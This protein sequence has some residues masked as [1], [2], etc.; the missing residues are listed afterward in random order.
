MSNPVEPETFNK[1]RRSVDAAFAMVAGIQL[2]V[3]TGVEEW[4]D[5]C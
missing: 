4:S 1:L 3:F 5:D 2:D